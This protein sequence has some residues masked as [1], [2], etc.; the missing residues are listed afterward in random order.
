M[1]LLLVRHGQSEWN[2][3]RRLQGQADIA[4]S[5][6]GR[7]QADALA[8]LVAGFSPDRVVTSDLRRARE[9]ADRL[10]FPHAVPEPG[11]REIAVG[12]WEG[13]SIEDLIRVSPADY[14]GWRAGRF[15]PDGGEL[16]DDFCSRTETAIGRA[17]GEGAKTVLVVCHGGV[18]RAILHRLAGIAPQQIMPVSPASLSALRIENG[19]V[20][21][22][23]YNLRP[24]GPEFDVAD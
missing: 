21:L 10:G 23:L 15:C 20:R 1:R 13:Q 7:A 4:L 12:R 5:A 18:I 22:E 19:S 14:H 8:P 24:S 17:T 2:A 6:L 16:W 11:L 9:T 3:G